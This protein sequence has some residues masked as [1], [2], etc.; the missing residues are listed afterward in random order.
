MITTRAP[1]EITISNIKTQQKL[2]QQLYM[3]KKTPGTTITQEQRP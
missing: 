1:T 2:Q 3:N